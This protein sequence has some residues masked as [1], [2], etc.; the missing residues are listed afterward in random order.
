MNDHNFLE[1]LAD[2]LN[3]R[4]S[5]NNVFGEPIQA[6][7]KVII[8]VAQVI[9]GM[10]GGYGRG[11]GQNK[12]SL[13]SD[14]SQTLS[15]DDELP[16]GGSGGGGGIYVIGKGVYEVTP[17]TTRFIPAHNW[18]QLVIALTAGFLLGRLFT[19]RLSPDRN[20]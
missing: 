4:A 14:S 18:R 6:G 3:Q 1:T 17:T 5:V 2:R 11:I 8:P 7:D 13:S 16:S 15:T 10:G 19:P 12:K 9:L 20:G